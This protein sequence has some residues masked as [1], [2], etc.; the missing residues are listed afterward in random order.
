MRKIRLKKK[1]NLYN[2]I[3]VLI[4][5]IFILG[6]FALKYFSKKLAPSIFKYASFQTK[7]IS[8][9]IINDA[10]A[11]NIT[12]KVKAEEIF[13]VTNDKNDEI[14][15]IDFNTASINKYLTDTTVTIQKNLKNI[16]NGNIDEIENL[17]NITKE[18]DKKTLKKGII[19][20]INSGF[21]F[22]NPILTNLGPKIP[23]KISLIG[24][25]ISYI[26]AEVND[27]GINNSIIKVYINLKVTEEVI[28]PFYG[29]TIDVEA[30]VPIAIKV[31]TGKV[32]QYYAGSSKQTSPI[33]F[34]ANNT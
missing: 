32:P 4:V 8:N 27:Y 30:K 22:N 12:S 31:V 19:Y 18:F 21:I 17:L 28:L 16:E 1:K 29:K 23:V 25:V 3:I 15:S 11:K 14:K 10:V 13:E 34:P 33:I 7:K 5:L 26:S 20:Y 9:I 24:D 6:F 2:I